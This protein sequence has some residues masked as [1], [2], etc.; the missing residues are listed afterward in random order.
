[1]LSKPLCRISSHCLV[2]SIYRQNGIS[3]ATTLQLCFEKL[4]LL[5]FDATTEAEYSNLELAYSLLS[6]VLNEMIEKQ[7]TTHSALRKVLTTIKLTFEL[8]T[9]RIEQCRSEILGTLRQNKLKFD[10]SGECFYNSVVLE[11]GL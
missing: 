1:M 5:S 11:T 3:P 6:L 7:L 4:V 8:D 9:A 10:P 2:Q